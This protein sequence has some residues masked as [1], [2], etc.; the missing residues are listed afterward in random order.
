MRVSSVAPNQSPTPHK[1]ATPLT[2]APTMAVS[3]IIV[4]DSTRLNNPK[5]NN[6]PAIVFITK[7]PFLSSSAFSVGGPARKG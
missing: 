4:N 6:P 3:P 7:S 1:T 2:N 5:N